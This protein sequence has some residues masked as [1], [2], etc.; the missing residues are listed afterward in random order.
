M[1]GRKGGSNACTVIAASIGKIYCSQIRIELPQSKILDRRWYSIVEN[2]IA[3]GNELYDLYVS[4]LSMM[5]GTTYRPLLDVH[6][7]FENFKSQLCILKIG[8]SKPVWLDI[9]TKPQ[10]CTLNYQLQ[11]FASQKKKCCTI[12]ICDNSSNIIVSDGKSAGIMMI[13]THYHQSCKSGTI[14]V[15]GFPSEAANFIFKNS[16]SKVATLTD[17]VFNVK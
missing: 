15:F 12:V 9:Q 1:C 6:E 10:S 16:F 17:V 4:K 3:E 11:V 7:V 13:D 2:G 14:F 5:Q 8:K